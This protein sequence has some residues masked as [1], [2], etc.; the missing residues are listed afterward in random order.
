MSVSIKINHT[1]DRLATRHAFRALRNPRGFLQEVGNLAVESAKARLNDVLRQDDDA[2]RSGRLTASITVFE[3]T[4]RHMR[5]GSN[6]P[7]A[8]QVHFGGTIYPRLAKALAIP[9][10]PALQRSKIGPREYAGELE[11]RP[12]W[13]KPNVFGVL[14]DPKKRQGGVMYALAHW[15]IQKARPWLYWS[16]GD[17]AR[18]REH[19]LPRFIRG[20]YGFLPGDEGGGDGG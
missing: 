19:I 4:D 7:Y 20:S 18:I 12:A 1:G 10:D 11:F 16:E 14:V 13:N 3:A 2:I 8:A 9:L 17:A 6:V 5:V 15:V